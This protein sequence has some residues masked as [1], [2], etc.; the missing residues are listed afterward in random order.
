MSSPDTLQSDFEQNLTFGR[1]PERLLDFDA[2]VEQL[3][4][5][6]ALIGPFATMF[7]FERSPQMP[8]PESRATATDLASSVE[9]VPSYEAEAPA[10]R[11]VAER[12]TGAAAIMFAWERPDLTEYRAEDLALAA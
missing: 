9:F 12:D 7:T 2:E 6:A 11:N 4:I 8:V 10:W 3:A 5:G 1:P